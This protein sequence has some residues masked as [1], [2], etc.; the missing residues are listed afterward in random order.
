MDAQETQKAKGE[1]ADDTE[2]AEA[3]EAL[4]IVVVSLSTC[5]KD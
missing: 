2:D 3:A 1:A 4:H 5:Q